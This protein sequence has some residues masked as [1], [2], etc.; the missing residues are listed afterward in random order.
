MNKNKVILI[1]FLFMLP[2]LFFTACTT[3][4]DVK[5]SILDKTTIDRIKLLEKENNITINYCDIPIEDDIVGEYALA[6][7]KKEIEEAIEAA[8]IILERLPKDWAITIS[9]PE[10]IVDENEK[11]EQINLVF[12]N[13][14]KTDDGD[15]IKGSFYYRKNNTICYLIDIHNYEPQIS[16]SETLVY[17][18]VQKKNMDEEKEILI[19]GDDG[20]KELRE[21]NSIVRR[22]TSYNPEGFKYYNNIQEISDED[23][24]YLY[25]NDDNINNIYF[26]NEEA[27]YSEYNDLIQTISPL[28]YIDNKEDLP[29]AYQSENIKNKSI[30]ALLSINAI[31]PDGVEHL[32]AW[33]VVLGG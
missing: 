25:T 4:K 21:K 24:K 33:Y 15:N 14:V 8:D 26:V 32:K 7:D 31:F 12:C 17:K 11:I 18:M 22:F 1:A 13:Y 10:V 6:T 30:S 23:K 3:E 27:L 19:M 20:N 2:V 5:K 9:N 16:I 28:L 29:K